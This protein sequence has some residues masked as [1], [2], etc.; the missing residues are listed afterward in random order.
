MKS[1][2]DPQTF[3]GQ[4][5][6]LGPVLARIDTGRGR[7]QL[8]ENQVPALLHQLFESARVASITASNAIEGVIIG[9]DRAQKIA[10]G[11]PRFRNRNQKEFA[12]YRDAIDS[13]IRRDSQDLLTVPFLLHLHRLLF[14]YAGGRGGYFK[15]SPNMIVAYEDGRKK[16]IFTPPSPSETE[17]LLTELFLRYRAAQDDRQAHPLILLSALVLD[18]L[19]IH[20]VAD[21]NGRLARL[22][23][24]HELL[25]LGYGVVRYISLEQGIYEAKNTYYASL[26]ESQRGWH[27]GQHTIW[28]WTTFLVRLIA[29]GYDVFEERVT[30]VGDHQGN[31]QTRVFEY[32]RNQ[33]PAT[34]SRRD[35]ERALPGISQAT[36][37]LV[38]TGLRDSGEVTSTGSGPGARWHR[39]V[40]R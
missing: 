34:F 40:N 23:T 36:I 2:I 20:P 10:A 25:A 26:Y 32:I 37:R 5:P 22:V 28:P 11:G 27:E 31:K 17:F 3:E 14:H 4:P 1:F 29:D 9:E 19:A 24:T 13:L 6:E 38:L 30:A 7:E 35:I 21:G 8:F 39:L 33:A 16:T 15:V 12:G 18:L